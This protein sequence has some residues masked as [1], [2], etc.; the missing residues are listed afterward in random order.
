MATVAFI[1][2]GNMGGPMATNLVQ[3]GHDVT[4]FDLAQAACDEL[5]DAGASVAESAADAARGSD[6]VISMLPAGKHVA[7]RFPRMRARWASIEACSSHPSL[8]FDVTMTI[9]GDGVRPRQPVR[10]S[11]TACDVRYWFSR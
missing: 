6:Y 2:L 11:P 7:A 10:A 8:S 5:Q 9:S 4:V 3:A 1:G